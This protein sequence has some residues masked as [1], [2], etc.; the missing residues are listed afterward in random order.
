MKTTSS[1]GEANVTF[2]NVCRW[3]CWVSVH[4]VISWWSV[5]T[6]RRHVS[7]SC[8]RRESFSN[9]ITHLSSVCSLIK[10]Y[11]CWCS[12]VGF[13]LK[14]D[15]QRKSRNMRVFQ[16]ISMSFF[17]SRYQEFKKKRKEAPLNQRWSFFLAVHKCFV[18][19]FIVVRMP[20]SNATKDPMLHLQVVFPS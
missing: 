3:C 7:L 9:K 8:C 19:N 16:H 18:Y 17:I 6:D 1:P 4:G 13:C 14:R 10:L 2:F 12:N 5:H 15:A 11:K 20:T